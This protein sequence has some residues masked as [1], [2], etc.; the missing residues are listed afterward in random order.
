MGSTIPTLK[1]GTPLDEFKDLHKSYSL[2]K[3][4]IEASIASHVS[5]TSPLLKSFAEDFLEGFECL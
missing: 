2:T 4:A 5:E 3:A 1:P